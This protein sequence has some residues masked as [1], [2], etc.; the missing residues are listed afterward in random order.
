MIAKSV[1][2]RGVTVLNGGNKGSSS[3]NFACVCEEGA[4]QNV[5]L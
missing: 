2:A 1:W 5:N 3:N 4:S